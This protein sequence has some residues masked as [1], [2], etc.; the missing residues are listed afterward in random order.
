MARSDS[1]ISVFCGIFS[2]SANVNNNV[3]R[4]KDNPVGN[5]GLMKARTMNHIKNTEQNR[6]P[7]IIILDFE[8][9]TK[10]AIRTTAV[11]AVKGESG[12]TVIDD[13]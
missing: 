2:V 11:D 1:V 8:D 9:G 10:M 12:S 4:K 13:G 7:S 6:Q 5:A 3:S